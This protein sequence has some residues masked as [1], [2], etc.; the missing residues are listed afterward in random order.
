ML[1]YVQLA[2]NIY[3][4]LT[5][6][7][8]QQ[9]QLLLE[10]LMKDIVAFSLYLDINIHIPI[11]NAAKKRLFDYII[12]AIKCYSLVK[13]PKYIK[14]IFFWL[15]GL[16]L[17]VGPLIDLNCTKSKSH[18]ENSNISNGVDIGNRVD[19]KISWKDGLSLLILVNLRIPIILKVKIVVII[20]I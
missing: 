6:H 16:S 8:E 19:N 9:V 13:L 4:R 10:E 11:S 12:R 5:A 17:L 20:T 14:S 3:F 18:S 15:V 7:F 1:F 2:K